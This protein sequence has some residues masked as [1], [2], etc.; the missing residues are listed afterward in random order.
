MSKEYHQVPEGNKRKW[1]NNVSKNDKGLEYFIAE[2]FVGGW[3]T[4]E[5]DDPVSVYSHTGYIIKYRN[6]PILWAYKL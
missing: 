2:D 1:T 6:Y 3:S 4:N 5:S